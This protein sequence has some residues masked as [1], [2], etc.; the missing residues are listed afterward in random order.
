MANV[1]LF[2]LDMLLGKPRF[3][4]GTRVSARLRI[5]NHFHHRSSL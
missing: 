4:L 1:A 2:K 3:L 5:N